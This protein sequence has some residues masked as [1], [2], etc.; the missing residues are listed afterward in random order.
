MF[1]PQPDAIRPMPCHPARMAQALADTVEAVI[2]VDTHTDTHS[3]CLVSAV[4]SVLAECTAPASPGDQGLHRPPTRPREHPP[5]SPSDGQALPRTTHL[6][7]PRSRR[8]RAVCRARLD[9]RTRRLTN[10]GASCGPRPN[11]R[12]RRGRPSTPSYHGSL[13]RA[14]KGSVS[15]RCPRCSDRGVLRPH[16]S[17]LTVCSVWARVRSPAVKGEYPPHATWKGDS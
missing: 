5:R 6:P 17:V 8:G 7:P 15:A 1:E 13:R 9:P 11:T 14:A 3:A 2:G 10:I 4:G 16:P 12:L